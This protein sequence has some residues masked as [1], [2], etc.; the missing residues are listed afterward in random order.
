VQNNNMSAKD[1]FGLIVRVFGL[2]GTLW[3]FFYLMSVLYYLMGGH[4][5]PGYTVY[6]YLLAAIVTLVPSVYFLRGAPHLIR[7][8]YPDASAADEPKRS[9]E[10]PPA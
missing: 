1:W 5:T 2:A 10:Y 6:H 3:G 7:F 9:I 4:P 8:A